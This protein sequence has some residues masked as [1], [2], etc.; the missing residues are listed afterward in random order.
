MSALGPL[1]GVKDG[2][3]I[4]CLAN[5]KCFK[6]VTQL[7]WFSYYWCSCINRNNDGEVR[8]LPFLI[9]VS[10]QLKRASAPS[11]SPESPIPGLPCSLLSLCNAPHPSLH[12]FLNH[13]FICCAP[14]TSCVPSYVS[15]SFSHF[16]LVPHR[17]LCSEVLFDA[18][19]SAWSTGGSS[20]ITSLSWA[21]LCHGWEQ[22]MSSPIA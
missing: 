14:Y 16:S 21:F 17:I 22:S 3:Q 10:L 19:H 7:L 1:W 6:H 4:K 13:V 18:S 2:F 12:L 20:K 9:C 15:A 5:S 8:L 11:L